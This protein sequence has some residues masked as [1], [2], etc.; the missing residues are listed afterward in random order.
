M[1]KQICR[2]AMQGSNELKGLGEIHLETLKRMILA[3]QLSA[4]EML[5]L[6]YVFLT[7]RQSE[8]SCFQ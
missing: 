1:T 6:I 5:L 7:L 8:A 4:S 3:F 2:G